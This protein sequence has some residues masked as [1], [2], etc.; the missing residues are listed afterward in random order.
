MIVGFLGKFV[1]E[2]YLKESE[3]RCLLVRTKNDFKNNLQI[4]R[5]LELEPEKMFL[6]RYIFIAKQKIRT[7]KAMCLMQTKN[8]C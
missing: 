5:A 1:I 7:Q 4:M 2:P 6:R 3:I 8:H